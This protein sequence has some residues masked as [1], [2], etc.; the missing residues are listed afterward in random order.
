MKTDSHSRAPERSVVVLSVCRTKL[1]RISFFFPYY[2][3]KA[4]TWFH[5]IVIVIIYHYDYHVN[6]IGLIK[7]HFSLI[8]VIFTVITLVEWLKGCWV[9]I[10]KSK[11]AETG[12]ITRQA[13]GSVIESIF[14]TSPYLYFCHCP[15]CRMGFNWLPWQLQH[16]SHS[17]QVHPSTMSLSIYCISFLRSVYRLSIGHLPPSAMP[18]ARWIAFTS[19]NWL[20]FPFFSSFQTCPRGLH[21]DGFHLQGFPTNMAVGSKQGNN[22]YCFSLSGNLLYTEASSAVSPGLN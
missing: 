1:N 10:P 3:W 6:N 9:E 15:S 20:D 19:A 16:V 12:P 21:T 17:R 7:I 8:W 22:A 18:R 13:C 11:L 2:A 4:L 5:E 14:Q